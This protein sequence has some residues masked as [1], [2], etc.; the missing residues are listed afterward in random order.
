MSSA[1]QPIYSKSCKN[2]LSSGTSLFQLY[3][4]NETESV[5]VAQVMKSSDTMV[6]SLSVHYSMLKYS[7]DR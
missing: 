3:K 5:F 1:E 7:Q 6:H 4:M 2:S